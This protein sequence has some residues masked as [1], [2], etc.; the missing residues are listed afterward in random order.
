ME[1]NRTDHSTPREYSPPRR[2]KKTAANRI[3]MNAIFYVLRTGCQWNALNDTGIYSSSTAHDRFQQWVRDGLLKRLWEEGLLAYDEAVG[4]DSTWL[5]MD[6]VMTK[7]PLGGGIGPNPT[8]RSKG[9]T[10]KTV[11]RHQRRS[12]GLGGGR[13]E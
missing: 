12:R 3:V 1:K 8:D 7:A 2:R 10:K 11:E 9:D 5:S 4:I 13:G 6:G